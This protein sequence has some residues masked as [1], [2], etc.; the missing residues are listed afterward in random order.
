MEDCQKSQFSAELFELLPHRP[1]MLLINEFVSV[2]ERSAEAKVV[3]DCHTPFCE[4]GLGVPAW[5]GL[6]YMGQ[7][8]A[9]IA[10]FQLKM[11]LVEP[12]LGFLLGTRKYQTWSD[13]FAEDS[14]LRVRCQE[15]AFVGNSLATF[16]CA[17]TYDNTSKLLASAILTVF[18]QP[19]SASE[20]K[21]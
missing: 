8:A 16:E 5:I 7:T 14:C 18:R 12:H 11:G 21:Q 4:S 9:L 1:P 3:I 6:E 17:V 2:N 19:K 20:S 10:G 13:Y 15:K